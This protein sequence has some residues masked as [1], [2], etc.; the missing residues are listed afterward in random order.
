M[1]IRALILKNRM[2]EVLLEHKNLIDMLERHDTDNAQKMMEKHI[3]IT[4]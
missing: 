1:G 2:K 3:K 4:M